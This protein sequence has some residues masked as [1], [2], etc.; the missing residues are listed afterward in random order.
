M[1][2][3]LRHFTLKCIRAIEQGSKRTPDTPFRTVSA[4]GQHTQRTALVQQQCSGD[5]GSAQAQNP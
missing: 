1:Y 2:F 4:Q 3:T 5:T